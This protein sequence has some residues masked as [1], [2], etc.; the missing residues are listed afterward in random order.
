M[1][2]LKPDEII[3][4]LIEHLRF[5]NYSQRTIKAYSSFAAKYIA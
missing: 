3:S 2:H 4:S 5:R 1:N